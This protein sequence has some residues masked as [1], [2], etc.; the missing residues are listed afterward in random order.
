MDEMQDTSRRTQWLE[1]SVDKLLHAENLSSSQLQWFVERMEEQID[2]KNL[3]RA[4]QDT[5]L[6]VLW[7]FARGTM[8]QLHNLIDVKTDSG[9]ASDK[10]IVKMA[11]LSA[12][13]MMMIAEKIHIE[14]TQ[15]QLD[16]KSSNE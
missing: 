10:A 2:S 16:N 15:K 11:A 13:Y 1:A 5:G 7:Q 8:A 3:N 14:R 12:I 4:I 6:L 9:Q